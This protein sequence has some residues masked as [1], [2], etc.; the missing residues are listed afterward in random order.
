[1]LYVVRVRRKAEYDLL[2]EADSRAELI[3]RLIHTANMVDD[4][5]KTQIVHIHPADDRP[6]DFFDSPHRR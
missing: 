6:V 2:I 3:Q 1:M 4:E 5:T